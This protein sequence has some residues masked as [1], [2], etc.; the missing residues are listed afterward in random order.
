MFKLFNQ[1]VSVYVTLRQEDYQTAMTML[2]QNGIPF[3]STIHSDAQRL[4]RNRTWGANPVTAGRFGFENTS[5]EL[6]TNREDA[7]RACY[8]LNRMNSR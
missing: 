7:E 4:A 1:W 3:K 2:Q 8:V 6:F 5:Y